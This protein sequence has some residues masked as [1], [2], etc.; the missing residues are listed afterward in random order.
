LE[1]GQHDLVRY[2]EEVNRQTKAWFDYYVRDGKIWPSLEP[3]RK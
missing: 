2:D 1:G 3:S